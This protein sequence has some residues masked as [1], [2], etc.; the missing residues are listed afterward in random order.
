MDSFE[1]DKEKDLLLQL[2]RG[3]SFQQIVDLLNEGKKL[4]DIIEHP[5]QKK[6]K[7]QKIFVVDID[8][9]IYLV[10]FVQAGKK[11]VLKTIY[12]SRKLTRKYL[13]G[14]DDEKEKL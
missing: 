6:Y 5:N 8:G 14:G 10:P 13:K 3:V 9:Y 12:P 11:V 1:W 2:E 7:Q 4:L